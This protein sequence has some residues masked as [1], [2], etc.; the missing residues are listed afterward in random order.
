MDVKEIVRTALEHTS[1]M[2]HDENISNLGLEEVE[3]DESQGEWIVT[4]GFSRPWDYPK[5]VFA[6]LQQTGGHPRR[7]Y[8]VL[9]IRESDGQVLSI[10]NR[11]TG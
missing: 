3:Y 6:Q 8:K 2:F 10:K 9:R 7:D 11:T 5:T 4:V 1:E